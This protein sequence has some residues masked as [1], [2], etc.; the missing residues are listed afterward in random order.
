MEVTVE[1]QLRRRFPEEVNPR[2]GH[3]FHF[4][5]R[6]DYPTSGVMCVAKHKQAS[7][8][9][10]KAFAER[11]TSKYYL[12]ILRGHVSCNLIDIDIPVG[13]YK[14]IFLLN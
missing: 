12:A 9:A 4:V 11:L 3:G 1:H 13:T 6:L 8:C 14:I 5:H 2:L 7:A 10:Q